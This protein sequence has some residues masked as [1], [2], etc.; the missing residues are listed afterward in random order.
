MKKG[1]KTAHLMEILFWRSNQEGHV[2]NRT[3]KTE[4]PPYLATTEK[5]AFAIII[6]KEDKNKRKNRILSLCQQ[7]H[8]LAE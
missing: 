1:T 2:C 4:M 3:T 5:L 6:S 7:K 8:N